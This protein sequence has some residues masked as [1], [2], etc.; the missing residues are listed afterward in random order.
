MAPAKVCLLRICHTFH[1]RSLEQN[2]ATQAIGWKGQQHNDTKTFQSCVG[3]ALLQP[4]PHLRPSPASNPTPGPPSCYW[5][6]SGL[7]CLLILA[8]SLSGLRCNDPDTKPH[9]HLQGGGGIDA[10]PLS[11]KVKEGSRWPGAFPSSFPWT[12]SPTLSITIEKIASRTT[13]SLVLMLDV[14]LHLGTFKDINQSM[15]LYSVP[16]MSWTLGHVL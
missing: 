1:T 6:M 15:S 12:R 16:A 4:N 14:G 9:L 10:T 2:P 5:L 8:P 13:S 7:P 11:L 3:V